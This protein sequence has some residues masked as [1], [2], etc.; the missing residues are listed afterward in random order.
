MEYI[1][2]EKIGGSATNNISTC[3]F[4]LIILT[5]VD[6]ECKSHKLLQRTIAFAFVFQRRKM[7]VMLD[8]HE[9]YIL[10]SL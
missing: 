9:F 8:E 2:C 10:W 5:T 7:N 3:N 1:H 4:S 6:G